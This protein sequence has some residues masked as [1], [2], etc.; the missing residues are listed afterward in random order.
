MS[1]NLWELLE[2]AAAEAADK[3]ALL[4]GDTSIT[5]RELRE[6]AL[7]WATRLREAGVAQDDRVGTALGNSPD[8]IALL[9]AA[10]RVGAVV[11]EA[12]PGT[13]EEKVRELLAAC[14][15]RL[16]V[17]GRELTVDVVDK[18][19]DAAGDGLAH[20]AN[21]SSTCGII[22][23]SGTTGS[24]K[25]VVLPHVN[26]W[27]NAELYIEYFGLQADDRTCLVLPLYFGMNKIA[28]LAHVLARATVILEDGLV[29][30][31]TALAAM[32][33]ARA[34][35][36]CAVPSICE[37]I[38]ERG[39]LERYTQNSLRY[40][41]IGAGRVTTSLLQRLQATFP[42]AQV[43]LTYGLSEMGLVAVMTA[44][45]LAGR[46]DAVGRPIRE[47]DVAIDDTGEILVSAPHAATGYFGDKASTQTSFTDAGIRTGDLGALDSDGYLLLKG[48]RKEI[49]KSGGENVYPREVEAVL[50]QHPDVARCFVCGVP[51]R[52]LGEA[53]KAYVVP[54]AN[55]RLELVELEKFIARRLSAVQCPSAIEACD[56]L[57]ENAV[58]KVIRRDVS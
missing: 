57:P 43:Y 51:D 13:D 45:G 42:R 9:F 7:T 31:N 18:P 5:Y 44:D 47:V 12:H 32:H 49:I 40:I 24:P 16:T 38:L 2:S 8:L 19:V 39:N 54:R 11:V 30:P 15:V 3:T 56:S 48:R 58:G 20:I 41:R 17:I 29:S 27:R 46:E 55:R 26:M 22:L 25:G 23:T 21:P 37:S 10:W 34:T 50:L 6:R 33:G 53:V 4:F 1:H 52:Q 28:M 35:G 36:L 14:G